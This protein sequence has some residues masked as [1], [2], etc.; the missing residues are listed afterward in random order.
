MHYSDQLIREIVDAGASGYVL[1]SDSDRDLLVAVEA[2]ARHKP[3]LL[4]APQK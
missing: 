3:S 1:K 4:L 2:L